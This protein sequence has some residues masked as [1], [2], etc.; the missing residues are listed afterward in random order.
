MKYLII[1]I[2]V[3]CLISFIRADTTFSDNPNTFW[4]SKEVPIVGGLGSSPPP[5]GGSLPDLIANHS[6]DYQN[7]SDTINQS[8]NQSTKPTTQTTVSVQWGGWLILGVLV[9]WMLVRY[10]KKNSNRKV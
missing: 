9:V 5:S 4:V 2:L 8:T 3:I 10:I 1:P 7:W 6:I